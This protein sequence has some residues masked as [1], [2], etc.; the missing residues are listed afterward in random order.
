M[1]PVILVLGA[2]GRTGLH[3]I[4]CCAKNSEKPT[5]H[6]FVRSPEKLSESDRSL[7]ASVQIG[8]ARNAEDVSAALHATKA[9]VLVLAIGGA[10]LQREANNVRQEIGEAL[11]EALRSDDEFSDVRVIAISSI[12]AGN[13]TIRIGFGVG[14]LLSRQLR[15]ALEDHTRQEELLTK[16]FADIGRTQ[17]LLIVRPT[18]LTVDKPCGNTFT[19]ENDDLPTST[20]DRADLAEWIVSQACD[21][22]QFGK[23]LN[24][25]KPK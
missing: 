3:V 2:S 19:S 12:G 4:R 8:D 18:G 5:V 1:A 13:T 14:L 11:M 6:A 15:Y 23:C 9:D 22:S 24:I 17:H 16:G 7:C 20:I 25:S 10:S 21:T